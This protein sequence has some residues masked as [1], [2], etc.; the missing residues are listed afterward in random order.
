MKRNNKFIAVAV[1][2]AICVSCI[3][4]RDISAYANIS[5]TVQT[6]VENGV[7][8]TITTRKSGDE[9]KTT[10]EYGEKKIETKLQ[11]G[12]VTATEY[13]YTG[14][15]FFGKDKF[16]VTR[17]KEI[18]IDKATQASEDVKA[19]YSWNSKTYT[20]ADWGSRYWYQYGTSSYNN[21]YLQI[22]CKASY[23][24]K[25]YKLSGD[26][27]GE[28]KSLTN[29]IKSCK[30]NY[31]LGSA[32]LNAGTLAVIVGLIIFDCVT[33]EIPV[34]V[35]VTAIVAVVGGYTASIKLLVSS[36]YD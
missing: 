15:N 20:P 16:E 34:G 18:Y 28:C 23:R 4:H 14:T 35:I 8:Y 29:E 12:I 9:T 13:E 33:I 30:K 1:A 25:Y 32:G 19:Q 22:G 26:K 24:L 21:A 6:I 36:Y 17:S 2:V 11:D 7:E 5:T 31:D 3:W 10:I 27:Q